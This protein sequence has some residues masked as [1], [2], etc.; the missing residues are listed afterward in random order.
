M[1]EV[2]LPSAGFVSTAVVVSDQDPLAVFDG[3]TDRLATIS[4]VEQV[5]EIVDQAD[6]L[7]RFVRHAAK[8]LLVQNHCAYIKLLAQRRAGELL[9]NIERSNPGESKAGKKDIGIRATLAHIEIA[10]TTARRWQQLATLPPEAITKE[11]QKANAAGEELTEIRVRALVGGWDE[12]SGESE[13]DFYE[14]V[15]KGMPEFTRDSTE[16]AQKIVVNLATREDVRKFEVLLGQR[17]TDRT[18]S[19]W[20]PYRGRE[21]RKDGLVYVADCEPAGK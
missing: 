9:G 13:G 18:N 3:I 12:R 20:F 1:R 7:R 10:P 11:W 17:L 8:G 19:I 2:G 5:I 6:A 4:N 21:N 14:R 16:P 15:W